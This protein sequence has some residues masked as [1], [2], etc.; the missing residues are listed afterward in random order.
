MTDPVEKIAPAVL[1]EVRALA[2]TAARPRRTRGAGLFG[3][4]YP[5]AF[6]ETA[7]T[8]DPG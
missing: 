5:R 1:Y 8:N 4:V 6:S 3:G 2:L 7:G